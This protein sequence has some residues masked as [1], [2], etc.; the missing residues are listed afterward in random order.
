M[1][2]GM[3]KQDRFFDFWG[4]LIEAKV[5]EI[6]EDFNEFREQMS[7]EEQ[8]KAFYE[9]LRKNERLL[10]I[11]GQ[12]EG[13][14]VILPWRGQKDGGEK[15]GQG[16]RKAGS[17]VVQ[18]KGQSGSRLDEQAK[19]AG[20]VFP[21]GDRA[22]NGEVGALRSNER[23]MP[24]EE[25]RSS[26]DVPGK[27]RP[28]GLPEVVVSAPGTGR[29]GLLPEGVGT[30]DV[31]IADIGIEPLRE[32]EGKAGLGESLKEQNAEVRSIQKPERGEELAADRAGGQVFVSK[33]AFAG[34]KQE[35]EQGGKGERVAREEREKEKGWKIQSDPQGEGEEGERKGLTKGGV[36]EDEGGLELMV[37]EPEGRVQQE[38]KDRSREQKLEKPEEWS[39][40]EEQ[41]KPQGLQKPEVAGESVEVAGESPGSAGNGMPGGKAG[42]DELLEERERLLESDGGLMKEWRTREELEQSLIGAGGRLHSDDRFYADNRERYVQVAGRYRELARLISTHPETKA[43][44]EDW[45]KRLTERERAESEYRKSLKPAVKDYVIRPS[46]SNGR[47]VPIHS[48][49]AGEHRYLDGARKLREDAVKLL[50]APSRYDDSGAWENW[51]KGNRDTFTNADFWTAGILELGRNLNVKAVYDRA[52]ENT[53]GQKLED[54]LTPGEYALLESYMDFLNAAEERAGDLSLGYEIGKAT[55]ELISDV[56]LSL[57]SGGAGKAV[58]GVAKRT[59]GNWMRSRVSGSVAKRL[60]KGLKHF[61]TEGIRAVTSTA[62]DPRTYGKIMRG[63]VTPKRGAD[64][65]ML[66]EENGLPVFQG[67]MDA[68]LEGGRDALAENWANGVIDRVKPMAGRYV[69]KRSDAGALFGELLQAKP[70]AL[71][72]KAWGTAAKQVLEDELLAP[73]AEALY[74]KGIKALTGNPRE[75]QEFGT[76]EEQLKF[77]GTLLPVV[78]LKG[79]VKAGRLLKAERSYGRSRE[80]VRGL[81]QECGLSRRETDVC[82][83]ELEGMSAGEFAD[84]AAP[85]VKQAGWTDPDRGKALYEAFGSFN[86]DKSVYHLLAGM[87]AEQGGEPK[88]SVPEEK[89]EMKEARQA[90]REREAAAEGGGADAGKLPYRENRDGSGLEAEVSLPAS[91]RLP[92]EA[93][94]SDPAVIRAKRD[95]AVHVPIQPEESG[96]GRVLR[97]KELGDVSLVWSD[98]KGEQRRAG[99]LND[100]KNGREMDEL[101]KQV[102]EVISNG[103]L[104]RNGK[105]RVTIQGDSFEADVRREGHGGWRLYGFRPSGKKGKV[106]AEGSKGRRKAAEKSGI[107][108]EAEAGGGLPVSVRAESVRAQDAGEGE[109]EAGT[110]EPQQ[111]RRSLDELMPDGEAFSWTG[112][113]SRRGGQRVTV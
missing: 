111:A 43:R 38:Q 36:P 26:I 81:L 39:S 9:Q 50:D 8:A 107:H 54:F 95:A 63:V 24:G 64:G 56:L 74:E 44:R 62:V 21:A 41:Q 61:A 51:A 105:R 34:E 68:V 69:R 45:K 7:T 108:E 17:E 25:S 82:L 109:A 71:Q 22:V 23:A 101:I 29:G 57:V 30:G 16:G 4:R 28:I 19:G 37:R 87:E 103:K 100:V 84:W 35:G 1:S 112:L 15:E 66:L 13:F 31:E 49:D 14:S 97:R 93:V 40:R 80:Q 32:R 58:S 12:F 27:M 73:V 91:G 20:G 3:S 10:G 11:P 110:G 70:G 55:P 46:T 113:L 76:V 77:F 48:E 86:R 75:L 106:D 59:L 98:R 78:M 42:L 104:V 6:P 79:G 90:N 83:A 99:I 92:V 60:A 47:L 33:Q 5:P 53:S 67:W 2:L 65:S 85:V 89:P 88:G 72:G 52:L 94:D 96:A 102:A 18:Q